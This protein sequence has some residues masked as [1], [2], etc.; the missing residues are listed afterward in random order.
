MSCVHHIE[1]KLKDLD[2]AVEVTPDLKLRTIKVSSRRSRDEVRKV[3]DDA[4][5]QVKDLN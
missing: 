4:G 1:D 3:I 5:Y 2:K